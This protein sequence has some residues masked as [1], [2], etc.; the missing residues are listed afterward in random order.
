[1][2]N[3]QVSSS[4][5]I[6]ATNRTHSAKSTRARITAWA[7]LGACMLLC[8][9]VPAAQLVQGRGNLDPAPRDK[10]RVPNYTPSLPDPVVG[11]SKAPFAVL[12][13]IVEPFVNVNHVPIR[14][15]ALTSDGTRLAALNTPGNSVR[16]FDIADPNP[17]NWTLLG[18][19]RTAWGPVAVAWWENPLCETQLLVLCSSSDTL[20]WLS[21]TGRVEGWLGLPAEPSDI[22]VDPVRN[23]AWVSCSAAGLVVEIELIKKSIGRKYRID[24]KHP[25]FL[26]FDGDNVL[27]APMHSGNN[28]TVQRG[29]VIFNAGPDGILDLSAAPQGLPDEDLFRLDTINKKRQPVVTAA[30][31][32]LF[33]HGT[34]PVS[35]AH[36][37]LGTDARNFELQSEPEARGIFSENRLAII[38]ALPP[39]NGAPVAPNQLIDL[40]DTDPI[41]PGVQYD[42]TRS[43]G[44]P[45]GLA[46]DSLGN[47]Y[48]A[49]LGTN[50][51]T[52]LDSTGAWVKEWNVGSIPRSLLPIA[53]GSNEYLAVHCSG[54]NKVELYLPAVGTGLVVTLDLGRDPTPQMV[55][56][57]RRVFYSSANSMHNN[58]SCNTCHVDGF[59]DMIAWDLSLRLPDSMGDYTVGVDDKGPMMTQTLRNIEPT[60]PFHWRGENADLKDFNAAFGGLLGG[61]PLDETPGG[62]FDKFEAFVFSLRERANPGES[63]RRVVSDALVPKDFP[64][65][66][67]AVRGQTLYLKVPTLGGRSCNDCHTLPT[68]TDNDI[69]RD[70]IGAPTARRSHFVVPPLPSFW[71][72][73]QPTLETVELSPGVF[74]VLP[75]LG[76]ALTAT[77][78]ADSL[79][80]FMIQP[81]FGLSDQQEFDVT[82]F[83]HQIDTGLPPL[84]HVGARV[85]F[86]SNCTPPSPFS[87][88]GPLLSPAV[89]GL[90]AS[91]SSTSAATS[92]TAIPAGLSADEVQELQN[93]VGKIVDLTDDSA[94]GEFDLVFVGEFA[95]QQV[96]GQYNILSPVLELTEDQSDL[97]VANLGVKNVLDNLVTQD[98]VGM[99]FPLPNGMGRTYREFDPSENL[100]PAAVVPGPGPTTVGSD[101]LGP[102]HPGPGAAPQSAPPSHADRSNQNQPYSS[103]AN[104]N[105][106]SAGSRDL[107]SASLAMGGTPGFREAKVL[108]ATVRT[109]K[110]IFYTTIPTRTETEF[111]PEGG[112]TR[113]VADN[114]LKWAHT[115]LLRNLEPDSVYDLRI[116]ATTNDGTSKVLNL[117][118]A[119]RSLPL[120]MPGQIVVDPLS[121][122]SPTLNSGGEL[123]FDSQFT[124]LEKSGDAAVNMA[125]TLDVLVYDVSAQ[126]WR[127]DQSGVLTGLSDATGAIVH[128]IYVS[129]LDVGD[130]VHVVVMDGRAFGT[131]PF[132]WS[133][134]DTT[135]EN[136]RAQT[137][138]TGTG[139]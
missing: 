44:Q 124:I 7:W 106:P 87:S 17:V 39:I 75:T 55:R 115:V 101:P 3:R 33:A 14:P 120:L 37:M 43:V 100:G 74:D 127:V 61:T 18:S 10:P 63:H 117:E 110:I 131:G 107:S 139:P 28:T 86:G 50:N 83:L 1:M 56:D 67:S 77:G 30:G 91:A 70:E 4:L 35:G 122:A 59:A 89:A 105:L 54:S 136:R 11:P 2:S 82:A 24:S 119:F 102:G 90:G 80:D 5:E 22:L 8:A 6:A 13:R 129:G 109:A 84:I 68:G 99:V 94:E 98:L 93:N 113:M 104:G 38:H 114:T 121:L 134:P 126:A 135:P 23:L 138:Y 34:N 12:D 85:G 116:T 9:M 79:H 15:M 96:L 19:R 16:I 128:E 97:P 65:T 60:Q 81:V 133:F 42:P 111:T 53:K 88:G 40:D 26:S 36:W 123:R 45:V 52:Q 118:D 69:F 132:K 47:G 76:G 25:T 48:I 51:V 57:G 73:L 58:Q 71:R 108:Y 21:D 95:G 41:L 31:T 20:L 32:I 103:G 66:T 112:P 137:T 27:V 92:L 49:G 62:D 29:G 130:Q 72:K 78:L 125:M 46:F 64:P